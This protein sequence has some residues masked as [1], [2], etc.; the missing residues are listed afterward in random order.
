MGDNNQLLRLADEIGTPF[1]AIELHYNA[2]SVLPPA[3]L[4]ATFAVLKKRARA[5][6]KPPWPDLVL[7]IGFRSVPVAL[8]IREESG[9]KAKLVR[10]GNP[11]VD[12]A[13]FDL[14]VTTPQYGVP[15]GPNLM[16]L[17]VGISTA[18]K[19]TPTADEQQWLD[20]LPRPHRLLLIGGDT[21]MWRL[22]AERMSTAASTLRRKCDR[23]G[24]SVIAVSSS[25]SSRA[26]Q[27]A[28]AKT[29]DGRRH[30]LVWGR[31]P[32]YSVLVSDADE[33]Y[34]TADSVAMTSDAAA[35]GKPVGLILPERS[36]SGRLF[37]GLAKIGL[38]IPIRDVERFWRA[39]QA[40]ELA[41]DLAKPVAGKLDL[42]P[43]A[44]VVST[45]RSLLKS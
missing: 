29:L 5:E 17:P 41:G 9:G 31:F 15:D 3:V 43:L 19:L 26:V 11:R 30:G 45:V 42:D 6:M 32:R 14:T 20:D 2:L 24:G 44:T 12:P 1:K 10:L 22:G 27:K 37:Y 34:V 8:A 39:V 23:D 7:G 35:T 21:F 33:L 25:R 4:G 13:K 38:P 28:V 36:A 16:R 18:A 40:N